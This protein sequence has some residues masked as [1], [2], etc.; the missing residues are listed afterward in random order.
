[1]GTNHQPPPPVI[2]VGTKE[3]RAIDE[4]YQR[5]ESMTLDPLNWNESLARSELQDLFE[6][7]WRW[8]WE[9]RT[10][11]GRLS[12]LDGT[13]SCDQCGALI[14]NER[15]ADHS[16]WHLGVRWDGDPV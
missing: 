11:R 16:Q 4:A 1:M 8:G 3:L 5:L 6:T 10:W 13:H 14:L 9:E 15:T 7:A 12:V 2:P